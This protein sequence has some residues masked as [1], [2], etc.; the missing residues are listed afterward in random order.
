M[1]KHNKSMRFQML[2]AQAII[3]LI[4]FSFVFFLLSYYKDVY[5]SKLTNNNTNMVNQ[6]STNIQRNYIDLNKTMDSFATNTILQQFMSE[7]DIYLKTQY[8]KTL[9][10]LMINYKKMNSEIKSIVL[11]TSDH[12]VYTDWRDINISVA[13]Q[14]LSQTKANTLSDLIFARNDYYIAFK[15]PVYHNSSIRKKIGDVLFVMNASFVTSYLQDGL[16]DNDSDFYVINSEHKIIASNNKEYISMNIPKSYEKYIDKK[17]VIDS[18]YIAIAKSI[19]N[20]ELSILCITPINVIFKDINFIEKVTIALTCICFALLLIVYFRFFERIYRSIN[21]FLTHMKNVEAGDINAK[22]QI[23][24]NLEFQRLSIGFNS[25][26][27]RINE[28]NE[29]NLDY[30]KKVL[31]KEIENKHI[32]LLA[33]QT[34]I[35]PHF[36]YNTLECI[37][38]MGVLYNSWE[39]QE[40]ATS[41]AFIFKYSV[42]GEHLVF[43]QDEIDVIEYYINIQQIRFPNKFN[44]VYE[45]D[46]NILSYKMLK[47]ILQPIIENNFKHGIE[48]STDFYTIYI[49]GEAINNKLVI[50]ICDNGAGMDEERLR[51]VQ[52]DLNNS[53][54]T[55]S[56][57]YSIGLSNINKRLHLYYGSEYGI[58]IESKKQVGT[59][60]I[61]TMPLVY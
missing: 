47:F 35:N 34:Q 10:N 5:K 28:L 40:M 54:E 37:N 41:L 27:S 42:K 32:Q 15:K 58:N 24:D 39:I 23:E 30:Q 59:K 1:R 17:Y 6:L 49:R 52:R 60:V 53:E 51:E 4:V 26:M 16:L 22:I 43:V 56:E 44:V 25:M 21:Q 48:N 45:I 38:S 61:L 46:Q 19:P 13:E 12:D 50:S 11:C 14:L 20:T 3:L 29:K 18:E 57:R 33:L 36:L 2:L 7:D 9:T 55:L 31:L 8:Y